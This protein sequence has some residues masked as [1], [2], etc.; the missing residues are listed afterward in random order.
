LY[1]TAFLLIAVAGAVSGQ[2]PATANPDALYAQRANLV[3]ARQAADV[4]AARLSGTPQDF[5]SAWKLARARYWLGGRATGDQIR[6]EFEAGAAAARQAVQS[7]PHRPEG[8]F[9]LAANLGGLAETQGR[10]TGLR[11]RKEIRAE[12]ERVLAI[13]PAFQDG[14]ADRALGRWYMKVPRLFGG[15]RSK[16]ETHFRRSLAYNP[17]ST[18]SLYFLAELLIEE[19]RASEA[20][21]VLR[22]LETAPIHP[23]WEAEDREFKAKASRLAASIRS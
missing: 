5:E 8:H 22:Q 13:D 11:L 4:W 23:A 1:I 21:E 18:A 12:L 15:S 17:H 7:Q 3:A 10:L 9:W 19:D 16:A 6:V 14:S 2:P 20:E